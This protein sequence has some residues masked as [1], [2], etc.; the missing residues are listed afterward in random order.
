MGMFDYIICRTQLPGTPPDFAS[1]EGHQFQTKDLDCLMGIYEITEDGHLRQIAGFAGAAKDERV[2]GTFSL[3]F[4]D[5]N[6]RS[7]YGDYKFTA[8]GEDWESVS[9]VAEFVDGKLH[10]LV[11]TERERGPALPI[12]AMHAIEQRGQDALIDLSEPAIGAQMYLQWGGQ[13]TGYP[14]TL[15]IKTARKWA[16]TTVSGDI[17]TLHPTDF[18]RILFYS[19][20]DAERMRAADEAAHR[21][22]LEAY[23]ALQQRK[24]N[25]VSQ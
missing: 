25:E 20:E 14:V 1:G 13:A 17:E 10:A 11:E 4:Y 15:A 2:D 6:V 12:A 5:S 21:R 3:H 19:R 18:G 9:Y 22:K 16:V 23:E 7:G 8:S 24:G